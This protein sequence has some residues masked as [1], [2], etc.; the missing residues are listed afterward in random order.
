MLR[1]IG[2]GASDSSKLLGINPFTTLNELLEEKRELKPADPAI[3]YK[4]TVRKGKELEDFIMQKVSKHLGME[5]YKP[6]N[7]Y[8]YKDTRLT[9]NFDGVC[10]I[11][12]YLVPVEIKV[13]SP[14]G[15]K[16]YNFDKCISE[17]V[18]DSNW[19]LDLKQLNAIKTRDTNCNFPI[20]YYTQ[21]QQ[22]AMFLNSPIGIVA[23]LDDSYWTM[24]Y[25]CVVSDQILWKELQV[26]EIKHRWNLHPEEKVLELVKNFNKE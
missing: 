18:E 21:V 1:H 26:A 25:Y 17:N 7:M 24:R 4:A 13:C 3:K 12:D 20:Y 22:Q 14:Y 10:K 8:K 5:V 2:F 23:V 9:V 11:K 6:K 15:R 16:Y 19:K